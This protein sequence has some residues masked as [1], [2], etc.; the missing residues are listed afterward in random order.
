VCYCHHT[1]SKLGLDFLF[2]VGGVGELISLCL[3]VCGISMFCKDG[4]LR[5][6]TKAFFLINFNFVA[7]IC[8]WN[9]DIRE[10]IL[11]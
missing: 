11:L 1:Y 2:F 8:V 3:F 4:I 10:R 5:S 7:F 6:Y 9:I